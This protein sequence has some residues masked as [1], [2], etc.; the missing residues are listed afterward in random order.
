M[1]ARR[2]A[3]NVSPEEPVAW[4]SLERAAFEDFPAV[5]SALQGA[6]K[7]RSFGL[8]LIYM[9]PLGVLVAAIYGL[10]IWGLAVAWGP[11][12]RVAA[13]PD[14]PERDIPM[15]GVIFA[16]AAVSLLVH[17]CVWFW[18]GRRANTAL[19]G[20]AHMMLVLGAIAAGRVTWR[21]V[22][23]SVPDWE[24]WA[25]PILACVVLGAVFSFLLLRA[26]R[27]T[28]A[29][30]DPVAR[31]DF[32]ASEAYLTAVRQS[33]S[34]VGDEDLVLIRDDLAAAI[35]DLE[36]RNVITH[37]DARRA[38]TAELGALAGHMQVDA[39]ATR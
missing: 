39:G 20:S 32:R 18:S 10:P 23:H 8:R 26:R 1:T 9:V 22:E 34:R 7:D 3:S 27:R 6:A 30:T 28:P 5:V 15:A 36:Q 14:T 11:F 31:P 13:A 29:A 4:G 33:V 24:L 35:D 17:A 2:T 38:R 37:A 12:W 25:I 16:A 21:G 19:L